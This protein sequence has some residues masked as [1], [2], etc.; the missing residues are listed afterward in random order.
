[1]RQHG[2]SAGFSLPELMVGVVVIGIVLVAT[3]PNFSSYRE[4][5]RMASVCDRLASAHRDARSRARSRNH[6]IVLDYRTGTNEMAIIDDVNDN[7]VADGGEKVEV[8]ALPDGVTMASTT[9]TD[10]QLVF[11]GRGRALGGGSITL[12]AGARVDAKLVRVSTGTG[13][14]RILTA[15]GCCSAGAAV[16]SRQRRSPRGFAVLA[17]ARAAPRP[18]RPPA[19]PDVLPNPLSRWRLGLAHRAVA[20]A[21][22]RERRN[23]YI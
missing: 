20:G 8:Y 15:G 6:Q 23:G 12:S 16:P 5:Q 3:I 18:P 19:S 17:R 1:M 11:N 10:D 22:A 2:P 14:V 4:N 7:G 9:F 13:E 21:D